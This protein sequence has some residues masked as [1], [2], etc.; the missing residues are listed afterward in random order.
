MINRISYNQ[1]VDIRSLLYDSFNIYFKQI[2]IGLK[3]FFIHL[4]AK[5]IV[6][7]ETN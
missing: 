6:I 1:V 4:F 3:K 2:D 5:K 7:D